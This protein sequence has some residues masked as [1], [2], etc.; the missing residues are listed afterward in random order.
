MI[1]QNQFLHNFI[2]DNSVPLKILLINKVMKNISFR[3]LTK[4]ETQKGFLI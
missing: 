3:N 2:I 4:F 1:F